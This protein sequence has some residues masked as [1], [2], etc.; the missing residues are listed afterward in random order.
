MVNAIEANNTWLGQYKDLEVDDS[1]FLS[2]TWSL[3]SQRLFLTALVQV[4]ETPFKWPDVEKRKISVVPWAA[5][6]DCCNEM[7]GWKCEWSELDLNANAAVSRADL[8]SADWVDG[9]WTYT[10]FSLLFLG[11]EDVKYTC[12]PASYKK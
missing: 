7:F 4:R 1:H 11:R 5:Q 3:T 12:T 2:K 9:K 10:T 6:T 8:I